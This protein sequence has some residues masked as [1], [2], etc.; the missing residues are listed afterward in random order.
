MK[1]WYNLARAFGERVCR[2]V[3]SGGYEAAYSATNHIK[4]DADARAFRGACFAF[5]HRKAPK[6]AVKSVTI[7]TAPARKSVGMAWLVELLSGVK[8][9]SLASV[10]KASG[11]PEIKTCVSFSTQL[12]ESVAA[13]KRAFWAAIK[14]FEFFGYKAD[15]NFWKTRALL[16]QIAD[17]I[18]SSKDVVEAGIDAA[19]SWLV[20]NQ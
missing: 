15:L 16:G 17:S 6:V 12:I 2:S 3:V 4:S 10:Q 20:S 7:K 1:S 13:R 8:A 11:K 14:G 9:M 19:Y 5:L 18:M